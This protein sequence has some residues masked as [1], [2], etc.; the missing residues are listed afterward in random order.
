MHYWKERMHKLP[1]HT[2]TLPQFPVQ[3]STILHCQWQPYIRRASDG[4]K[5]AHLLWVQAMTLSGYKGL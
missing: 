2:L 4:G 5:L 1:V 3:I